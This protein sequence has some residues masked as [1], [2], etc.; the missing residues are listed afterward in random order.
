MWRYYVY[1]HK[2]ADTGEVFY[3]GKGTVRKRR[4]SVD[5]ERANCA[6]KR[7]GY[8]ANTVNKHGLVVEIVASFISD[9][10]S[11]RFEIKL[12]AEYGRDKLVNMTNGGDGSAGLVYSNELRKKRS[13]AAQRPRSE[14][15]IQSIRKAR[16]N[17]GNGGIVKL[18][19]KLP[20]SWRKNI[21]NA[22]KGENNSQY[23]KVT[24]IARKVINT[25]TGNE[26]DS[27]TAAAESVGIKMKTLYNKLSGHRPNNTNLRFM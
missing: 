1:I 17:G 16:K 3:V 24:A 7:N 2:K 26:F 25:E 18:G 9:K 8:W 19:D 5:Y 14:K 22:V 13:V 23:G 11:Q 10:D 27:V 15:W 20:D 6:S 21:S 4:K 12:I